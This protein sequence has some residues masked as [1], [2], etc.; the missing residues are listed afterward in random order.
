M[1]HSDQGFYYT[2]RVYVNKL[3]EFGVTQSMSRRGNCL[4]N[5]VIES[6]F[7]HTKDEVELKSCKVFEEVK[8]MIDNYVYF[9]NNGRYQWGLDG[10]TPVEYRKYLL[11]NKKCLLEI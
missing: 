1:I 9:Y 3:K 2:N 7:G 11:E 5:A 6:F 8:K 4:D 10:M